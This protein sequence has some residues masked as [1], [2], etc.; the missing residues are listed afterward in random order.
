M[1]KKILVISF[2]MLTSLNTHAAYQWS[3]LGEVTNFYVSPA[4]KGTRVKH[5]MQSVFTQSNTKCTNNDWLVLEKSAVN[6]EYY[7]Q[8]Y[9][10][11]LGLYMSGKKVS[12]RVSGC[13]EESFPTID[14][15]SAK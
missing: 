14:Y 9:S 10:L 8:M 4:I 11:L 13:T 15:I 6:E 2:F 5:S 1:I 12:I 3:G 7:D